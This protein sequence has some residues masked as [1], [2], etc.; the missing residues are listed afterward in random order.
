M[1][2]VW[3]LACAVALSCRL[4]AGLSQARVASSG[5]LRSD[6]CEC[7]DW[8]AAYKQIGYC[9]G[10]LEFV[11]GSQEGYS[12]AVKS[13][14]DLAGAGSTYPASV[15]AFVNPDAAHAS[16]RSDL[17]EDMGGEFCE[18][19]YQKLSGNHCVKA[20]TINAPSVWYGQ[21]WCYVSSSCKALNGGAELTTPKATGTSVKLCQEG[22]DSTLA[23]MPPTEVFSLARKDG[24]GFGLVVKLAW[25]YMGEDF[26]KIGAFWDLDCKTHTALC[27]SGEEPG[28]VKHTV[29]SFPRVPESTATELQAIVDS[30][31]TVVF[32]F[33]DHS[34]DKI[35]VKGQETW[36][37]ADNGPVCLR[38]CATLEAGM[39]QSMPYAVSDD[40]RDFVVLPPPHMPEKNAEMTDCHF[41][42][43]GSMCF[44]DASK[45]P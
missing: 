40:P 10:G 26:R 36:H 37:M 34:S 17:S 27:N 29:M 15:S 35:V 21:S 25:P 7:L 18:G 13:D 39:L 6:G 45:W 24:L 30:G 42:L 38:G 32:D 2:S 19:F 14:L 12:P 8:G 22:A 41:L 43:S 31:K 23:A 9:G 33:W 16:Q 1:P 44:P 3:S 28:G 20:T 5:A 4:A 11:A